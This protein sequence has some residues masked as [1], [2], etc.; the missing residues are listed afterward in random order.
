MLS[1]VFLPSGKTCLGR[2]PYILI[3]VVLHVIYLTVA[4]QLDEMPTLFLL[5]FLLFTY[6]K[7]NINAQRARDSGLKG[8]YV[9]I[10]S[11]IIY[12]AS[13]VLGYFFGEDCTSLG[14]KIGNGFDLLVF[15][16]FLLAPG[17]QKTTR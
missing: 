4:F 6:I 8:R 12:L 2:G 16:I 14:V 5:S 3:F 13:A 11:L 15:F 9:V 1:K 7:I 17:Q 10:P